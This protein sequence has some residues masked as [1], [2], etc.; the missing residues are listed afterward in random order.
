MLI[1]IHE[2]GVVIEV[3]IVCEFIQG[4]AQ[5]LRRLLRNTV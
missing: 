5:R 1:K 3:A 4:V 2:I